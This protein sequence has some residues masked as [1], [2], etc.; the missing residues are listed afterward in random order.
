MNGWVESIKQERRP[1]QWV[2]RAVVDTAKGRQSIVIRATKL[3]TA[4][5]MLALHGAD[6]VVV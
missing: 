5:E 6:W 3:K 2:V 1:R 4:R